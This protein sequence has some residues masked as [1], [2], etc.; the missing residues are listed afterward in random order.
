MIL[1]IDANPFFAGFLRNSVSRKIILS[2]KIVLYSPDWLND[3]FK[4]NEYELMEKFPDSSRF[5]GTKK[6]LLQFINIVPYKEYSTYM[7]KALKLTKH[8][9]DAPYFALAL[10]LKCAIWSDEK[11][12]KRQTKVEVFSTSELIKDLEL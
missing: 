1:V 10:S 3:E 7:E 2:E 6:L 8:T 9:K 5:F 4:R 11:A 12:F